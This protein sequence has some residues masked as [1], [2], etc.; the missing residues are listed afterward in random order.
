MNRSLIGAFVVGVLCLTASSP[1]AAPLAKGATGND[2]IQHWN[3]IA[4]K[5]VV[6]DHSYTFGP[7]EQGGPTRASRALAVIHIAMYDAVNA[8]DGSF[9]PYIPVGSP[10][11]RASMDAAVAQA[12]HDTLVVLYP[13][14]AA[15]F[16]RELLKSLNAVPVRRGRAA[17]VAVGAE[18]AANILAVRLVDGSDDGQT[19][20]YPAGNDPGEHQADPLHPNQGLLSPGWGQ[21]DT[22]SGIDVTAAD[23]RIPAPPALTSPAYTLAYLDVLMLGGDGVTTPTM[24]SK[25]ETEIGIFWAYDGTIGL[26]PPPVCFN[27]IL[28]VLAKQ[29]G[30]TVVENAR[31]FALANIALADAGI[32]CWDSKYFYNF[33]R[34]IVAIR[35]ADTDDNPYTM[36]F[37]NWTPL[38]A[39]ASNRSGTDFTPAFPAYASGHATFGAAFFKTLA[40]FYG[41]DDISFRLNSDEFNGRTTDSQGRHRRSVTRRFDSFSQA[42]IENARSRIYLGVHWQFDANAGIDQ[43]VTIADYVFDNLLQP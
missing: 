28:Q 36:H 14:Q 37:A 1:L 23:V 17:G 6:E 3:S 16:D 10:T 2:A 42:A 20:I 22:F 29:E 33:W 4:V 13:A 25:E 24:R 34:P 27:Q 11:F 21:V 7:A 19:P 12:A 43:G 30:N 40:N 8:I 15:V 38:G 41:T 31:L 39:P 35:N 32:A 5:A 26:G 18:A 9:A